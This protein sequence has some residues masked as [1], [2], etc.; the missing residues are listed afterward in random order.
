MREK[1]NHNDRIELGR[2]SNYTGWK[3][4]KREKS[5][6]SSKTLII[7]GLL[8]RFSF[9]LANWAIGELANWK[10]GEWENWQNR[11]N[12]QNGIIRKLNK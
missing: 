11:Q 6:P 4:G 3:G 2:V 10:I 5:T 8:N 1:N 9:T 12:R 7:Q